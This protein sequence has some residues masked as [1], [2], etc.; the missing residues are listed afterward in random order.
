MSQALGA[1]SQANQRE[2]DDLLGEIAF[3]KVLL[4]S[5]DDSVENREATEDEVRAEIKSLEKQVRTLRRGPS[6]TTSA[7]QST[8]IQSQPVASTSSTSNSC[9]DTAM[10]HFSAA[11]SQ[12]GYQGTL[13]EIYF[14]CC[15]PYIGPHLKNHKDTL[16]FTLIY[17]NSLE[18]CL[19][20][21]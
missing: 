3:Q 4:S 13:A 6:T 20:L 2:I 8:T 18:R 15:M 14:F 19:T 5:I 17:S 21:K 7:S 10:D 9:K 16:H 11:G 1:S 12:N